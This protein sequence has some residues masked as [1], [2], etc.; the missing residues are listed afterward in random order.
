MKIYD[1]E[2]KKELESVTLFLTPDESLELASGAKDL[3]E[4]PHK[5]H[6]HISNKNYNREITVAVYTNE[7]IG[8]FNEESRRII[9]GDE[10]EA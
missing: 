6:L 10:G 8:H 9:L 3:S 1:H 7:N 5:H 4:N 2:N